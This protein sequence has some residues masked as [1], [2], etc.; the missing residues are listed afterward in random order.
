M[1]EAAAIL[2]EEIVVGVQALE[3]GRPGWEFQL[4]HLLAV[5][6]SFLIVLNLTFVLLKII[7][8]PLVSF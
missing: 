7:V 1:L 3:S 8:T 2:V 4:L 6:A 5:W